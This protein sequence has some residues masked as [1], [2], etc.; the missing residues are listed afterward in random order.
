MLSAAHETS[1]GGIQAR[2]ARQGM[3]P[4]SCVL[5]PTKDVAYL[6]SLLYDISS[7]ISKVTFATAI[8]PIID[9]VL[10]CLSNFY[11]KCNRMVGALRNECFD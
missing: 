6:M 5:S 11:S 1:T 8:C 10:L 4:G 9:T 2:D 7:C 3:M